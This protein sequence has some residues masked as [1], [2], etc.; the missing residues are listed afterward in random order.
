MGALYLGYTVRGRVPRSG[1]AKPEETAHQH[2][3]YVHST[4]E[5][6]IL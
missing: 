4:V 2:L 1:G 5:P 3:D 6:T